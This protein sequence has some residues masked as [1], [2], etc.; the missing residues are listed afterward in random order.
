MLLDARSNSLVVTGE[1]AAVEAAWQMVQQLDTRGE[2]GPRELRVIELK[3][4]DAATV[5]PMVGN[6]FAELVKGLHERTAKVRL[7]QRIG[8]IHRYGQEHDCLIFNFVARN[9]RE[10]RVLTKLLNRLAEI[11]RAL[12]TDNVFDVVGEASAGG[13]SRCHLCGPMAGSC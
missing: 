12:G 13:V 11:R 3:S 7:E 2:S 8:R 5:A 1:H 6:L 9:T 4:A 10:G